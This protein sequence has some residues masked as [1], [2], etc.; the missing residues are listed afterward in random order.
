MK[1]WQDFLASTTTSGTIRTLAAPNHFEE[2]FTT[3]NEI[4]FSFR[5]ANHLLDNLFRFSYYDY[6]D[7]FD[8]ITSGENALSIYPKT[9]VHKIDLIPDLSTETVSDTTHP[10]FV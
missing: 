7:R 2:S 1:D 6:V 9:P 8:K 10:G 3:S 5:P 4:D